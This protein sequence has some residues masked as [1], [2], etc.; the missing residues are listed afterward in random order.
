MVLF[1]GLT[2]PASTGGSNAN[3]F[4]YLDGT[5]ELGFYG[6]K[7]QPPWQG[8]QPNGAGTAGLCVA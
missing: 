1:I 2:D 7:A 6:T 4:F 5:Q 3:R 8:S